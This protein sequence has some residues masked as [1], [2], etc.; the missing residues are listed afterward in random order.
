MGDLIPFR[1]R[2]HRWAKVRAYKPV[3]S[4]AQWQGTNKR[5]RVARLLT[6]WR[7]W[8]LLV[9]LMGM[10]YYYDPGLIEPPALLANKP[11]PVAGIFTRCGPGRGTNCVIDGDT[12]KLG[13]RKVRIIGIDAPEMHPPRC[14]QEQLKGEAAT[15]AL[16]YLLNQGP[17]AMVG[18][19]GGGR[20]MYGRDLRSLSRTKTDGSIQSIAN[21]MLATGTVKSYLGGLRGDWC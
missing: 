3:L 8:V 14:E 9:G 13:E 11:E 10:W 4:N 16:Q 15:A 12:F 21:A 17:F 20:D 7:P 1:R 2:K 19:V 18:R 6:A 5:R